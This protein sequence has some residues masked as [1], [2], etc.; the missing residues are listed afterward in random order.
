MSKPSDRRL[1][2]L[3]SG[4]Q[5]LYDEYCESLMESLASKY[6]GHPNGKRLACADF[7]ADPAKARMERLL[8]LGEVMKINRSIRLD[9]EKCL[10]TLQKPLD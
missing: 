7:L 8:L 9:G 3:Q 6:E 2:E 4:L 5:G 10:G 1:N